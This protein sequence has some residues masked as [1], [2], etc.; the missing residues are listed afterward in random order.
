MRAIRQEVLGGPEVLHLRHVPR[1][2]PGP[3]EVLVRVTAAG[4]NPLDWKTRATGVFLGR[5]P[6]TL[7][8]DVAGVVIALAEGVTRFAVGDRVFGMPRFPSEAAAY[9]E[10]LTAPSRHLA[11]IPEQPQRRE[12][13]GTSDGRTYGLAGPRRD[14]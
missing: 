4:V 13:R 10:Y 6:F 3:T 2:E 8:A 9:A 14:C 11:R 7:G 1:P 5:P 12:G